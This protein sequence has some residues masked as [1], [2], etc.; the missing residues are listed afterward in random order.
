MYYFKYFTSASLGNVMAVG[1]RQKSVFSEKE[2]DIA[3]Q[4]VLVLWKKFRMRNG[5]VGDIGVETWIPTLWLNCAVFLVVGVEMSKGIFYASKPQ[6]VAIT[7]VHYSD[8]EEWHCGIAGV[9]RQY[10]FGHILS[11][12]L[13]EQ[14]LFS[15]VGDALKSWPQIWELRE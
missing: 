12:T 1:R 10:N 13:W 11:K 7:V 3:V 15:K 2:D 6:R 5:V 8:I 14:I 4:Q 9:W